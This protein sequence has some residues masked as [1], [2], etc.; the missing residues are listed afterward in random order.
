MTLSLSF[1]FSTHELAD[2]DAASSP[3]E[4]RVVDSSL[5]FLVLNAPLEGDVI[6]RDAIDPFISEPRRLLFLPSVPIFDRPRFYQLVAPRLVHIRVACQNFAFLKI[7]VV[8]LQEFFPIE[9]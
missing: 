4:L 5:R 8:K 3:L 6:V 2:A 9:S 7:L 1:F